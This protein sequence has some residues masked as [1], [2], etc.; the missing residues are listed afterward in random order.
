MC[1]IYPRKKKKKKRK[2]NKIC[3]EITN[4]KSAKE[5]TRPSALVF[6]VA[7]GYH[8]LLVVSSSPSNNLSILIVTSLAGRPRE[9]SVYKTR[10]EKREEERKRSSLDFN[11]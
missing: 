6:P 5:L 1:W 3:I 8:V 10:E 4:K 2:K 9:V 11:M 7:T